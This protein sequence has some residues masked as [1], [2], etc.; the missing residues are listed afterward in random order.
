MAGELSATLEIKDTNVAEVLAKAN[1]GTV[2]YT[3][4]IKNAQKATDELGAK[5]TSV[6]ST[7]IKK[8]KEA[9]E[10]QEKHTNKIK[11]TARAMTA[12]GGATGGAFGKLGMAST[13]SG[14]LMAVGVAATAAGLAWK[15]FAEGV[16]ASVAAMEAGIESANKL[17][18]AIKSNKEKSAASGLKDAKLV[19]ELSFLDTGKEDLVGKA[20]GLAQDH[21]LAG[22]FKEGAGLIIAS[23]TG[24]GAKL[25]AKQREDAIK[26]AIFASESGAMSSTEAMQ[27]ILGNK[28]LTT[29]LRAEKRGDFAKYEEIGAKVVAMKAA[30]TGSM[31]AISGAMSD[32]QLHQ[33]SVNIGR[34]RSNEIAT[35]ARDVNRYAAGNEEID[36]VRTVGAVPDARE[37]FLNKL[38]PGRES[39]RAQLK[40]LEEDQ[41]KKQQIEEQLREDTKKNPLLIPWAISAGFQR[42]AAD[43]KIEAVRNE[44]NPATEV[45]T[46]RKM[47]TGFKK[48]SENDE[49]LRQTLNRLAAAI[50]NQGAR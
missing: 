32:E 37:N 5:T 16:D 20:Q 30:P 25:N 3:A 13:L 7:K 29:S 19:Q 15:V 18:D 24:E 46:P 38:N 41:Y 8:T 39:I 1:T 10:E 50:E 26:A 44:L 21:G 27:T 14:P 36:R 33:I 22:G 49:L 42:S 47:S 43:K 4:S 48:G 23:R 17:K 45:N 28:N 2:T 40:P 11:E 12:L 6:H 34:A 9:A 31:T 35:R